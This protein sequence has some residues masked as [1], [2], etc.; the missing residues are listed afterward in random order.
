M[1]KTTDLVGTI[2]T[3]RFP[4]NCNALPPRARQVLDLLV[5]GHTNA[6]IAEELGVKLQTVKNHIQRLCRNVGIDGTHARIDLVL[7][8]GLLIKEA[9]TSA[10]EAADRAWASLTEPQKRIEALLVTNLTGKVI[11][12]VTGISPHSM[13]DLLCGPSGIYEKLGVSN[14]LELVVWHIAHRF[15]EWWWNEPYRFPNSKHLLVAVPDSRQRPP[16]SIHDR[17]AIIRGTTKSSRK[18]SGSF[19]LITKPADLCRV[20]G[21]SSDLFRFGL[22]ARSRR[23]GR[24]D[25]KQH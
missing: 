21:I 22:Q 14:R 3:L 6:M 1:R 25:R 23:P 5:Q 15:A 11:A 8:Y 19:A 9:S 10:N 18:D 20:M 24:P 17:E 13:R 7:L 2:E 4:Y 12:E 16:A